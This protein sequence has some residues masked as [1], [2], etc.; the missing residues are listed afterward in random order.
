[1]PK[2][3]SINFK[4]DIIICKLKKNLFNID[5]FRCKK[6][7]YV[8]YLKKD[9]LDDQ[10]NSIGQTWLFV[11]KQKDVIGFVTIAMAELNKSHHQKLKNF[12]HSH[13]PAVLIGQLAT[14]QDYESLGVGK[15]MIYWVITEAI[16]YSKNIGC[17]LI[18]LNP[19]DDVVS[20]YRKLGFI[21][22]PTS[23]RKKDLM[24]YNLASIKTG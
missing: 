5:D 11:N 4:K 17:K 14:H 12:P 8:N 19:E 22:I 6:Q 13:I 23:G 16:N 1:L 24:F 3:P 9:A 10:E 7:A 18:I 2:H 20:W 21:H 15:H